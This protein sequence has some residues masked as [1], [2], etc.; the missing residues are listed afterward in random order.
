MY[1]LADKLYEAEYSK[2]CSL[3]KQESTYGTLEEFSRKSQSMREQGDKG[4]KAGDRDLITQK[5]K[6]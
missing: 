5:L 2:C 4:G 3:Q 1:T 6:K